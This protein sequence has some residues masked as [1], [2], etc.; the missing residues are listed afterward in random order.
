MISSVGNPGV[1]N[2][3]IKTNT[4]FKPKYTNSVIKRF[5]KKLMIFHQI[6]SVVYIYN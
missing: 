1:V 4:V 5:L 3:A 6:F 2:A